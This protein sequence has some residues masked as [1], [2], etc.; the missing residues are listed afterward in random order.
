M[1]DLSRKLRSAAVATAI[2]SAALVAG[3][4]RPASNPGTAVAAD[5]PVAA[6]PLAEAATAAAPAPAFSPADVDFFEK[7]VRPV[8]AENCFKC[9]N[10]KKQ[11]GGLRLDAR[12]FVV[13]GGEHGPAVDLAAKDMGTLLRAVG[14]AD[15]DMQMPPDGK[16]PQAKFDVLTKWAKLNAPW[17]AGEM[18]AAAAA[19][20]AAHA[21]DP[22]AT[23]P[24][25]N[26]D[27][28]AYKVPVRPAVPPVKDP[29]LAAWSKS[30][31]DAFVASK[32]EARGLTPADRADKVALVRRAFY[33]LT[34]LPPSP[35]EVD[36]FVNDTSDQAWSN[37][38]D[39]LLASPHYGEKWGRHWLDLVR[40][41]ETHGYER[42]AAKPQAWRYRDYVIRAFNADKPYDQFL[43]EQLAGDELDAVTPDT[44]IA[45]GYYRLGVWDDEPADR[46]LARYD[47]L[48]GVVSTTSSVVLGMSVGCA[49]CH[50]HKKDPILAKDY[51]ALLAFFQ[52]VGDM[53]AKNLR[54]VADDGA[55]QAYEKVAAEKK[56]REAELYRKVYAIEQQFLSAAAAKGVDTGKLAGADLADLSFKF[57]RDTWETLPDFTNLKAEDAGA[58]AENFVSL[59]PATRNEAIGLAFDGK[60]KVPADGQYTFHLKAS[61]GVR[62]TVDGKVVIDR[63][64][65]GRT[66]ADFTT[67]L[68]A[69]LQPFKLDYFNSY[70]TPQLSLAWSGP[71]FDRRML[72]REPGETSAD[73]KVLAADSREAAQQWMFHLGKQPDGWQKLRFKPEQWQQAPGGFGEKGTPGSVVRTEW[74]TPEIYLRRDFTLDGPPP[75][76]ASLSV[77]HDEDVEVYLNGVL[78]YQAAGSSK[79]YERVP[80]ADAAVKA[81]KKGRNVIAVHCKQTIGGQYVDVGLIETTAGVELAELIRK[82]GEAVLGPKLALEHARLTAALDASRKAPLPS[83]G[84]EVM[85][86]NEP[87]RG[88]PTN[89]LIRGNPGSEGAPVKP[90]FPTVLVPKG[91]TDPVLPKASPDGQSSGK[92]RVLAE[93][94]ASDKNP[95]T[96]RVMANR[97]W[98]YHFGRGLVPSPNEYGRLG[99]PCTHPELLD[100]LATELVAGGWKLKPM[101]RQ[102]M[103]SNAYQMS[104]KA[105]PEGLAADPANNLFWRFNMRRL[106]A[107]EVRDSMLAAAG[108]L[109]LDAFGPS[110]YPPIPKA[111]LAGQSRPGEGWGKSTE[112]EASRRSVYVHVKRAL[113]VPILN[114][115]DQADT[116]GSCPVRFTTTVPT[117]ALG[118]LNGEFT[119]EQA[120]KLA[121]RLTK[122]APGSLEK[123]V[124]AAVRLTTGREPTAAEVKTDVDFVAKLKAK[125]AAMTD[126]DALRLYCLMALNTNEFVYLD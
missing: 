106:A 69:G 80:V 59:A 18:P 73:G 114:I 83:A 76:S 58:V 123:Q 67:T 39:R 104:A 116:D 84:L 118:M 36:A 124:T 110:V 99:E 2:A 40:Y 29:K 72:S 96:A 24:E 38:V 42:D 5:A 46:P 6:G 126:A 8:L 92:R 3:N 28:W 71:G 15:E 30:P 93:W 22:S 60:L 68:K 117:Q 9:H 108:N 61:E 47:V 7:Q 54:V 119:N 26:R 79:R 87:G 16:L 13:K 63:P 88:R 11:K 51:Y 85:A 103:L 65:R 37:L 70:A 111:V 44:M 94:L 50:D 109:N 77:H 125:D 102:I 21:V 91:Q 52:D 41:A 20:P 45:T 90:G 43:K 74:K 56:A 19:V 100:Y 97:L 78:A 98:Q 10:D 55:K 95:L 49:R 82:H 120:A 27:Y 64:M 105:T 32:L 75:A 35:A 115:H 101:H 23:D 112:A 1:H 62:L 33:D 17:P 122:E 4:L 86:V 89:I 57:Y 12:A 113:L 81:L 14:Y 48:D 107:E 66:S 25:K 53:N 34:G 121:D 31:I